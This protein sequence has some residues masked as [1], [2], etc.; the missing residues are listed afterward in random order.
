MPS[1][2]DNFLRGIEGKQIADT[3]NLNKLRN[4][5]RLNEKLKNISKLLY[6]FT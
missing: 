4:Y 5:K 6:H 3:L 1:Q 2:N